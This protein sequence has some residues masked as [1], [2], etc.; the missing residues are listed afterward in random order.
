MAFNEK[1]FKVIKLL[2]P[3]SRAFWMF[4]EKKLTNFFSGFTAVPD[5]FREY[6]H[7]IWFDVFP[8]TTRELEKWGEQFGVQFFPQ[9]ESDQIMVIDTEWK[10]KGGQSAY[11]IQAQLQ[12]AG[13]NVQVHENNPPVDPDIFLSSNFVMVAGGPNAYAGRSDAYAGRT[14]GEL[15]VNGPILTNVPSYLSIAG[16]PNC[17]CGNAIAYC[18]Y[19]QKM[20]TYDKIYSIT[21]DPTYW[22]FF[23]FIGGDATR[24]PVTNE[25]T[26]IE[27]ANVPFN[28]EKEFKNLILK[29]K[30][31]QTWV[32]LL[33][34]YV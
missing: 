22:P 28:R 32:G 17:C 21:D 19:F 16:N 26:N 30:P 14:G 3:K 20:N 1:F 6:L 8:S 31:S 9:N 12:N 15:L 13:F 25:L 18:G 5:D 10:S 4:V 34:S 2:A 7:Q 23:F 29:L 33:N 11:Y 24:D 27:N